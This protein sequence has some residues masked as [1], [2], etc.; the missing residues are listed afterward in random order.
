M[1]TGHKVWDILLSF[2]AALQHVR[3]SQTKQSQKQALRKHGV[4]TYSRCTTLAQPG[5]ESQIKS[6]IVHEQQGC[7][8][9]LKQSV[10]LC[11]VSTTPPKLRPGFYRQGTLR[12]APAS[13]IWYTVLASIEWGSGLIPEPWPRC[14]HAPLRM[15]GA[16]RRATPQVLT[17]KF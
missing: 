5:S 16:T 14:G 9:R 10:P 7:S 3:R 6:C 17:R 4:H 13:G 1:Q 2:P 8:P 15:R 12:P 11:K